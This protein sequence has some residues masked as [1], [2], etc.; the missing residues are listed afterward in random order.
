MTLPHCYRILELPDGSFDVETDGVEVAQYQS[1]YDALEDMK[2]EFRRSKGNPSNW[3]LV[4]PDKEILL[5]PLDL[6]DIV[7]F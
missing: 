7:S 5:S 1:A 4:S 6:H 2:R 3:Y